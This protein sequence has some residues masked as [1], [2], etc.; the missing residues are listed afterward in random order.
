MCLLTSRPNHLTCHALACQAG[1]Q[2]HFS[3]NIWLQQN[4]A[5][6][7]TKSTFKLNDSR[8]NPNRKVQYWWVVGMVEGQNLDLPTDV[9]TPVMGSTFTFV[10]LVDQGPRIPPL[11][12]LPRGRG[13][14]PSATPGTGPT[15]CGAASLHSHM[16][17]RG[18]HSLQTGL[19]LSA[20]ETGREGKKG[21]SEADI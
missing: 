16:E 12:P 19:R 13:R 10:P 14:R 5:F 2:F 1:F 20:P 4:N 7:G 15:P 17:S 11:Y 3:K 21:R 6:L 9:V 8:L 18:F